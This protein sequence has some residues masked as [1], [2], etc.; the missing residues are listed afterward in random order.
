MNTSNSG[1]PNGDSFGSQFA[2][3]ISSSLVNCL[4][5]TM[6]EQSEELEALE[7][8][9]KECYNSNTFFKVF[10][11]RFAMKEQGELIPVLERRAKVIRDISVA[12]EEQKQVLEDSLRSS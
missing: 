11:V 9:L 7:D 6:R 10:S 1:N 12:G 8:K 2:E 5:Q 3:Y 4:K